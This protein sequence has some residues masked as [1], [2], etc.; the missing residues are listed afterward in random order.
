[1][2]LQQ[3]ILNLIR[4]ALEAME[5]TPRARA[6]VDVY[7]ALEESGQI[8]IRVVDTGPGLSEDVLKR[9]FDPFFTTKST[10]MGMGLSIS[11]SIITAHGGQL[12]V[13]NNDNGSGVTFTVLLMARPARL[14]DN[15]SGS[16]V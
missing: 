11:H 15:I 14:P 6:R 8:S 10:G 1:V 4:N 13:A 16:I 5:E 7:T 3:V 9:V 2:Q 12:F